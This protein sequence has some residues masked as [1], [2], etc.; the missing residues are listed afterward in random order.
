MSRWFVQLDVSTLHQH[1]KQ[2][3]MSRWLVQLD[4]RTLHQHHKQYSVFCWFVQLDVRT[5]RS[6]L[7]N[8][9]SSFPSRDNHNKWPYISNYASKCMEISY[10]ID[11]SLVSVDLKERVWRCSRNIRPTPNQQ[12]RFTHALSRKLAVHAAITRPS[13]QNC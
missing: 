6:I 3:S 5:L 12:Y 7:S 13:F 8:I 10:A 2:Y 9:R 1:H 11:S 4:V